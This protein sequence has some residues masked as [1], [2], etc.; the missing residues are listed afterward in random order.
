MPSASPGGGF[1]EESEPEGFTWRSR[2]DELTSE[3]SLDVAW[4]PGKPRSPLEPEAEG[5]VVCVCVCVCVCTTHL[6]LCTGRFH[7]A[8]LIRPGQLRETF[9]D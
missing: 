7:A 1:R 4:A 3:A 2:R 9:L 5:G 8:P 6:V